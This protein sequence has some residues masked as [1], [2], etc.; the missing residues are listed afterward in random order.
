MPVSR[1]SSSGRISGLPYELDNPRAHCGQNEL[2]LALEHVS[3]S[4]K[5]VLEGSRNVTFWCTPKPLS[6]AIGVSL[7]ASTNLFG[8]VNNIMHAVT[9]L[10]LSCIC[11]MLH[12]VLVFGKLS[13]SEEILK[14]TR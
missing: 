5:I 1:L 9:S 14:Y 11:I 4:V 6:C 2:N 12:G 8:V 13:E 10:F 3:R 7:H